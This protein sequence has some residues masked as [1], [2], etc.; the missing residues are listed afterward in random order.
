MAEDA[1]PATE[2][3]SDP[4]P[5]AVPLPQD[6]E[7]AKEGWHLDRTS[8]EVRPHRSALR[9]AATQSELVTCN[10]QVRFVGLLDEEASL[11][12]PRFHLAITASPAALH[13]REP[14]VVAIAALVM[15]TPR[16]RAGD[17]STANRR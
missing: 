2:A 15:G 7:V 12:A 16:S 4:P 6:D 9:V 13:A 5:A 14:H 3:K 8:A 10:L 17:E 11:R 1:A